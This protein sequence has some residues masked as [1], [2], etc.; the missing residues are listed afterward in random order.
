[1]KRPFRVLAMKL[2]QPLMRYW[3]DPEKDQVAQYNN[4]KGEPCP[5]CEV[6]PSKCACGL[7]HD[8]CLGHIEG[9]RSACC[10]H[11]LGVGHVAMGTARW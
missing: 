4:E 6:V 9:A 5:H 10:G 7:T 11:G 8:P 3:Y 1:M 2:A